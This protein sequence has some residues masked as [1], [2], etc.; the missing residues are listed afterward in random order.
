VTDAPAVRPLRIAPFPNGELGIV[1]EDGHESYYPGRE[2]RCA[3]ACAGCVDEGSGR[4]VL[5]DE[6]VSAGVRPLEV[7]PVGQYAIAIRWSDGHDTGIYTFAR[8][9]ELG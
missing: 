3:C 2:L 9:R 1:W 7:H 6:S 5:R 8:L 4:K